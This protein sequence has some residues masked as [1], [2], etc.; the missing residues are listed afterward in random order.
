MM[1]NATGWI[2]GWMDGGVWSRAA[3]VALAVTVLLVVMN[4][5]SRI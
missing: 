5:L 1:N 3:V 2:N 4:H